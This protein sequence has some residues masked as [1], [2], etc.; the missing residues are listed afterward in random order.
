VDVAAARRA[1]P[2]AFGPPPAVRARALAAWAALAGLVVYCLWSMDVSPGRL[3]A[4]VGRL[5]WLVALML[6]PSTGGRLLDYLGG[7]GETLG[8]AFLGTLLATV[9]AVPLGFLGARNVVPT[10]LF[11]VGLRRGLDGVRGVDALIWALMFVNVVGLGPFAGV[12]AL[13][14]SDLGTLAKLLAEAIENIDR[15]PIDGV[16]AAGGSNLHVVRFAI[17]PQ[18]SPVIASNALYFFESNTRSAS[19]LGVVGAGGIGFHLAD[20]IRLNNWD[21]VGFIVLLILV[22]VGAIDALSQ[23][24]RLRLIRGR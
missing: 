10:W 11:H 12:M 18:V 5:G 8:M 2:A 24:I 1:L 23:V 3:A 22:T 19:I 15:G 9:A 7:I 21:E 14:L 13:A 16:R 4:G 6:P 17:L 20:R